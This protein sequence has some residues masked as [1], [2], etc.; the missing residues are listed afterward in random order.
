MGS[1]GATGENRGFVVVLVHTAVWF[2][3]DRSLCIL[4]EGDRLQTE[5]KKSEEE[6]IRFRLSAV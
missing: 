1:S 4:M 2:L 3:S 5:D 6:M